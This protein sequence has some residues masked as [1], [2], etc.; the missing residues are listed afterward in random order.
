MNKYFNQ[1]SLDN[2]YNQSID[3]RDILIYIHPQ[4]FL[5]IAMSGFS[6]N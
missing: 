5:N 3:S 4:E 6:K 2:A 1:E